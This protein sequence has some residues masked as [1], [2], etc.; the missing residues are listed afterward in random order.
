MTNSI[1]HP[2]EYFTEA[3]MPFPIT[4]ALR[5]VADSPYTFRIV[6]YPDG[7]QALQG[8]YSWHEGW[9][10]GTIWKEMPV[11]LVDDNG[12]EFEKDVL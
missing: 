10:F 4:Q 8:G 11:I 6:Q 9:K 12:M 5:T 1:T 2:K 7:R 3:E